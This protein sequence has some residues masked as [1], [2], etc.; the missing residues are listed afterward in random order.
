MQSKRI[1]WN[2]LTGIL[3]IL[4]LALLLAASL[5]FGRL[6]SLA[7]GLMPDGNFS[8][9][10]E[11]NALI[12]KI[13][14][15]VGGIVISALAVGLGSGKFI[16]FRSWGK[17]Y[18]SD[19]AGFIRAFKPTKIDTTTVVILLM[20]LAAAVIFRL[21]RIYDG[22]THDEAYTFIVFSSTTL[23]NILTNYHLPNNHI[24]NSIL[25][26]FSTHLFGIQPWAV[27]LPALLAGLL[28]IPGTY[29]L[30]R[31]IYNKN[32]AI[33]SALLVAILPGAIQY[34]TTAR[35][36]SLVALFTVLILWL[37]NYVRSSKNMFAWSLLVIISALG[38]YSVPVFLFPFGIVFA[39]LFFESLTSNLEA[40]SSRINF[41][42]YWLLA[43]FF[44]AVLVLILYTPVFIYS[45]ADKV[46][47]NSWV[48]PESWIGFIP[49]IPG[50]L[51][52]VWQEWTSSFSTGWAFV[53]LPG[54]LL[55]IIFHRRITH[56]NFPIQIAAILWI[57]ILMLVQRPIGVTK[58]WVFLQAP[59][60]M[61]CAAGWMGLF[62]DLRLGLAHNVSLASIV[63]G[64]VVLVTTAGAIAEVPG[65]SKRWAARGPAE[66]T[67]L[68]IKDQLEPRDLII[69]KAPYDASIW[70]YSRLHGLA[71]SHFDKRLIFEHLFI[72]VSK[73][74]NQTVQSVLHN[75]GPEMLTVDPSEARLII[76]FQNLDTYLLSQR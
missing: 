65:I 37:A 28:L 29:A 26:Y 18:F 6:K 48:T 55:G 47:A 41:F 33:I 52:F 39:W 4:A 42:K 27:R 67:V 10:T 7:D 64:V 62:K 24:L 51:V 17:R 32:T 21:I 54:F 57:A 44:S 46:F 31:I 22:M 59:F 12:F 72:I 25:I 36:Y 74:D 13:L 68:F 11:S 63:T 60:L 34:A 35:G 50:H 38:F 70:Y 49:S 75:R 5:P 43:G 56:Q 8:S 73:T 69:V 16:Q 15:G 3:V 58:I 19:L 2:I 20:I 40:Y 45:G 14:L 66:N 61:W 71:D 30:A 23:F 9:L 1:I 53:L 76:N